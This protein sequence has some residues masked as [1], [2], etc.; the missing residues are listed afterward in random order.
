MGSFKKTNRQKTFLL[1]AILLGISLQLHYQFILVIVGLFL[2]Y[3]VVYR[4][5]V[6][7]VLTF[8]IGLAIGFSPLILFEL[9]NNFYNIKT[10]F[11]ILQNYEKANKADARL[12]PHYYLTISFFTILVIM[13]L[14]NANR[15]YFKKQ[16]NI[17][18]HFLISLTIFLF[19]W[20]AV[21]NF[22]RPVEA[23]WAP[24]EKWNYLYDYKIY[25]IVKK[26]NLN[27]FNI[28]NLAYDTISVVPKYLLKKD[29]IITNYDDYWHNKYLFVI[30]KDDQYF[31]N[32]AYEVKYFHPSRLI[33]KWK[34]NKQYTMFLLERVAN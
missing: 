26:N 32:P 30:N 22:K 6:K 14:I 5:N 1:L 33:N 16:P 20:A 15:S 18:K 34:L 24:V 9:R 4:V 12:T 11:F 28:A 25:E 19:C 17:Y 2:Y 27:N 3:F 13:A 7:Y 10:V 21:K 23:F 31:N 29:K 8:I